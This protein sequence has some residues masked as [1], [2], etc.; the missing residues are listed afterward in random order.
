MVET[1]LVL[2]A[3]NV[4][5]AGSVKSRHGMWNQNKIAKEY[6]SEKEFLFEQVSFQRW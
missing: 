4:L 5:A 2:H 1:H 3:A 6:L